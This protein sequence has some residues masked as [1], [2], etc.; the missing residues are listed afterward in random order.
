M[1]AV[2]AE[3]VLEFY[4]DADLRMRDLPF[5]NADL[6]LELIG[7]QD[8][9]PL[10]ES[11]SSMS[12]SEPVT[13]LEHRYLAILITPWCINLWVGFGHSA[14]PD[15]L[16]AGGIW[17]LK[18]RAQEQTREQEAD[19]SVYEL[20]L[21]FNARLGWYASG[22]LTSATSQFESHQQAR[23]WAED[24]LK[25]LVPGDVSESGGTR[26]S[27]PQDTTR[28]QRLTSTMSRRDLLSGWFRKPA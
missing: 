20:T 14:A 2:S 7:W 25:L 17:R 6:T 10:L 13:G 26:E 27:E 5:Y 16:S 4:R 24:I 22:S 21:A 28:T 8:L 15:D 23:A 18:L 9:E 12:G 1:S 11:P 19:S 3:Q